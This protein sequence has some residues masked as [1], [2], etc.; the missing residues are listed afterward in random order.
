MKIIL[1][2]VKRAGQGHQR[3]MSVQK[4][5]RVSKETYK[6]PRRPDVDENGSSRGLNKSIRDLFNINNYHK[7]T[8]KCQ[9]ESYSYLTRRGP[10]K[11]IRNLI[12]INNYR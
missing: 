1:L 6:C 10:A 12:N 11:S 9:E 5:L 8:Y 4:D 2:D 3:P 7:K